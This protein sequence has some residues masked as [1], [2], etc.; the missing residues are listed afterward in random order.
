MCLGVVY[1]STPYIIVWQ[2]AFNFPKRRLDIT[3]VA[4]QVYIQANTAEFL[5]QQRQRA[6]AASETGTSG[7]DEISG[8]SRLGGTIWSACPDLNGKEAHIASVI[9]QIAND[10][11]VTVKKEE[12]LLMDDD[13][14]NVRTAITFGHLAFQVQQNVDYDSFDSFH[15]ML[16]L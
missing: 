10:H 9:G 1:A 11:N 6:T 2:H 14:D 12:V 15:T 3:L 16:M 8:A 5:Q 4:K 13:I 7:N